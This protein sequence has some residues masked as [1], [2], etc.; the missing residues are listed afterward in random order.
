MAISLQGIFITIEGIDGVGK[1]TQARI[2][3]EKLSERGVGVVMTREPGG[4]PGGDLIRQLLEGQHSGYWSVET[5][6][7]LFTAARRDHLDRTVLPA[8]STGRVVISDRFVD[9]TRAYQGLSCQASRDLVDD[10]H[11][12]M[13]RLDPDLTFI[14]DLDID[15]ATARI[16]QRQGS[17]LRFERLG[18]KTSD[19]RREFLRIAE[20]FPQRCRVVDAAQSMAS[21]SAYILSETLR[22]L[23]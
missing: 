21:T 3:G 13:I 7:L 2:L 19:L 8:L 9:S 12:R 15:A 4:S 10:L 11:F 1:S 17:D 23:T 18:K 14:L 5:E 22:L 16:R 20:E 6:I